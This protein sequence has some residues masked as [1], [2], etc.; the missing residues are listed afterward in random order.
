[1]PR[2]DTEDPPVGPSE[3]RWLVVYDG[4]CGFC[5][6]T[7]NR[8]LARDREGRVVARPFQA[9]GVL[10][11]TGIS[12]A[13]A[14]RAVFLVAPDGRRWSGAAA[15]ARI[16]RLLP[17]R[18]WAGRILELPGIRLLADRAYRWIAGHRSLVSRLTGIGHGGG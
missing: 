15:V 1:M 6:A 4:D 9:R 2:W 10:R 5:R 13:E 8:A 14:E 7:V 12:R 3:H 18:A 17:G 16:L 11:E